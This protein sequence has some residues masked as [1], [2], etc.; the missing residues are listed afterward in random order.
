MTATTKNNYTLGSLFSGSGGFELGGV[1]NG[2]NPLWNSEIKPFP[3]LVTHK[4]FPDTIQ[5]GNI[6]DISGKEIPPVDV[7]TFGSPCFPA[8]T[9]VLTDKGYKSIEKIE[10]GDMVLTHKNRFRKVLKTGGTPQQDI[11]ELNAQGILPIKATG[12]HPFIVR[13]IKDKDN[14]SF[15]E[16]YQKQLHEMSDKDYIGVPILSTEENPLNFTESE[17]YDLGR[18]M[19]QKYNLAEEKDNYINYGN[20]YVVLNE[21][22]KEFA[23]KEEIPF[24]ILNLPTNLIKAFVKGY[25]EY[26]VSYMKHK[27]FCKT[28]S[29]NFAIGLSLAIQ[30]AFKTGCY[31]CKSKV[32][33][34]DRYI[35]SF[36]PSPK[37]SPNY[38]ITDNIVWYPVYDVKKLD[39]QS[40]VF[41]IEVEE[42]HTYVAQNCI[43]HNCQDLSQAGKREGL[44]GSRSSLFYEAI[45]IIK[46]M[47]LK[48]NGKY[49]QYIVWENVMGSLTSHQGNDFRIVLETI[50]KIEDETAT[51]PMPANGKWLTAGQV[52]GD[53]Y[54]IA[55]RALDAQWWGV[56]QRRRRIYLIADLTGRSAGDLLFKFESLSGYSPQ[57]CCKTDS[58]G[59]N[60]SGNTF[61]TDN[62][63][64]G[65]GRNDGKVSSGLRNDTDSRI[66]ETGKSN[67]SGRTTHIL[68]NVASTLRSS[69]G[70]PKHSSD[71]HGR[72]V[73]GFCG[74]NS[75]TAGGLSQAKE[76]SPV[77]SCTK[78]GSVLI[79]HGFDAYNSKLTKDTSGTLGVNCCTSTGRNTVLCVNDQ[80]GDSLNIEKGETSPTLRAEAHGNHPIVL[81]RAFYNQGVNAKYSPKV[82]SDE[83]SPTIVAQK[84]PPLVIEDKSICLQGSMIGRKD[85]NG[86][87][88]NGINEEVSFTLNTLDRHAVTSKRTARRFTPLE[89]GRLQG[90]PDFWCDN[91][92]TTNPTEEEINYWWN[93]WETY[94]KIT[95]DYKKPKTRKQIELWLKNPTSSD[96]PMYVMWGN[97]VAL[98]NVN[99]IMAAIKWGLDRKAGDFS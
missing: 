69:A 49:P 65:T 84:Q 78:R 29:F 71:I 75:V 13:T 70:A 45:R 36:N 17:L 55:W 26:D 44:N 88:G 8:G 92:A 35:V 62:K 23:N 27:T 43:V 77:L 60:F 47:R 42:D 64:P 16:P 95:D 72:L 12:N 66:S 83:T 31:I 52:M 20:T 24:E 48:S 28:E 82:Y 63:F 46:E 68:N 67:S 73:I 57:G 32:F 11:Y 76:R 96:E 18:Y 9:L 41:N 51:I 89:C 74:D 10:T 56:P 5:L 59:S 3:M 61:G 91:L 19:G 38:F 30:K 54:S 86:P 7:V 94:R 37:T 93:A 87:Q 39:I 14:F 85:K 79:A 25:F 4:N 40:D 81:D 22:T 99:F 90:F 33:S 58:S 50:A 97:G 21:K 6:S 53:N 80:G 98:P 1:L 2:F 34:T 15:T